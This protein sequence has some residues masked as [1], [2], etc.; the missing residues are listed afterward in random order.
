M[1]PAQLFG[2]GLA[3]LLALMAIA[4]DAEESRWEKSI[5]A[6]E[7]RDAAEPLPQ[8]AILFLGSSSIV[9]WD[10]AASFPDLQV[11]NCGFG[12]SQIAD[13][14]EFAHRIAL[15][16]KPHTIVFYAGDNDI[17]AG[18]SPKR[19]FKDYRKFVRLVGDALP[20]TR[21]LFVA[22][23]PSISR[24]RL[25][26]D[27]RRAKARIRAFSEKND[28]L[29]YIDIDAPMLGDDGRPRKELFVADGLHLSPAG[30]ELWNGIVKPYLEE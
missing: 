14:I 30:Y 28:R 9:Y 15:P 20:E 23:K 8:N 25:V 6:F 3:F 21:I 2:L 12:G 1:R 22:I 10:T 29:E 13:S 19:V 26:E 5:Q 24:W 7:E 16:Y 11:I 17:A 18:K 27:M 4:V